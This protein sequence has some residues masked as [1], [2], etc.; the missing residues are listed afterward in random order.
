MFETNIAG[1]LNFC[2]IAL[3]AAFVAEP[4][5]AQ[6]EEVTV[7]AQRREQSL[8]DVPIAINAL[9]GDSLAENNITKT[10]DIVEVFPNLS[11]NVR[12][13]YNSGVAIRGV[14]TDNFHISGQQSVGTYI[15]DVSIV[16]PFISTIG[17]Y[18]MDRVEVLRGPQNTLYGRNTTGGAVLWHTRKAT[19]GEGLNGQA[20]IGAGDGG[21]VELEGAIGF[22]LGD[23]I[24]L[25]IAAMDRSFDGIWKDV[26]TGKDTGGGYDRSGGRINLQW[27]I[28]SDTNLSFGLSTGRTEGED[29]AYTYRGN[30]L[31]DGSVDP[32][33]ESITAEVTGLND[34]YVAV[35]AAQVDLNPYLAD[36]FAQNT[37][38]VIVNPTPGPNNRLINY[39][40]ILGETY[41]H[42]EAGY[43]ADWDAARISLNHSFSSVDLSL[44]AA[45]DELSLE[46]HNIADLTGFGSSQY[47]EWDVL[48]LEARLSSTGDG[49]LRWLGGIYYSTE[50]SIQDTWVHNGGAAGGQGVAPGIDIDSKYDNVSIYAQ[51]DYQF[52]PALNGTVGLRYTDDKLA[53]PTDGWAR[54]VC[55]F[56][57]TV[58]GLS[59]WSRDV[60]S[61]GCP[62]FTPGQLG[63]R[64]EATN[65]QSLSETGWRLSLDYQFGD[66]SMAY[67]SA[68]EGFKGGAYDNRPLATGENPID[69]EYLT[70]YEIGFK[71][72]LSGGNVQLNGAVF[73]YDWEDLQLFDI[74]NG[75]AFL[76]NVPGTD[77]QGAE[78]EAQ[79]A[80]NDNWYF[81][82]AVGV[83]DTEVTDVSGLPDGSSVTKGAEVPNTP[84][85]TANLLATYTTELG[86]GELSV[87]GSWRYASEYFYNFTQTPGRKTAPS[88]DYLNAN[89]TYSFGN[90]RQHTLRVYGN[91]LTEEFHCSGIQDGPAG[92]Q[93]YSCRVATFGEALFG[94]NFK[95]EF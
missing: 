93:N 71:S 77:L 46:A 39:S 20:S 28:S 21:L 10:D 14:G 47:G 86:N 7:T 30:R 95:T 57:P 94:I 23:N 48:Q 40:T 45:Y 53:T 68:S 22:D 24:A 75:T 38:M 69:P 12:S 33:F 84:D 19:P 85:L 9:A 62:G 63:P 42:P 73:M 37:G 82:L 3:I 90:D 52:T 83:V 18:D 65:S 59:T 13:A 81:Q 55:G 56:A 16:S 25:R 49:N 79:I 60:R 70:A 66:A 1:R 58:N 34:N 4:A 78:L 91:N 67:I 64:N 41:V 6:I 92:G 11:T 26:V 36:Q 5:I 32:D 27:D 15:D 72:T 87:T 17:V 88:Q 61:E 8:N 35:S 31:T 80:P 29:N 43:D 54:T 51:M 2:A 50:D 44:L 89:I 76:L 74:I